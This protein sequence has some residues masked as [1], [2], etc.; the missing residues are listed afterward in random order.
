MLHDIS[1]R[2]AYV[3]LHDIPSAFRCRAACRGWRRRWRKASRPSPSPAIRVH[4]MQTSADDTAFGL[5][6]PLLE[7]P[8]AVT[9]VSDTT[10]ARYGVTRRR[11]ISPPSR[12]RPIPPAIMAS[13]ARS[14][15]AAPWRKIISAASSGRKIA[16]PIPR[17]WAMPPRSKFCAGRLRRSMARARWAG[18]SISCPRAPAPSDTLG[19]EV[20]LTYGSY[21]KRNLTAQLGVPVRSGRGG[22]RRCMPMARSTTVSASIAACIP[23]ISC[24]NCRAILAPGDWSLRRRLHV[25]PFQWRCADAGLEPADPGADRQ[26]HLHH[27]PQHLACRMPTAMAG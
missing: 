22:G 6:K 5:D 10:I 19:G 3:R 20:T 13:K 15:C 25:L 11:T 27:R 23:A 9:V 14:I 1:I 7:T 17:R 16:A 24:W 21:S 26:R 18:W 4:L 8:R 2:N 12:H